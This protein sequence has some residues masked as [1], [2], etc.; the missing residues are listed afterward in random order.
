MSIRSDAGAE[1]LAPPHRESLLMVMA[2]AM[3]LAF[4]VWMAMLNNFTENVIGF[5][6][7]DIGAIQAIREIPGFLAFLVVYLILVIREQRLALVS[8]F[9][10]GLGVAMT[11]YLPFF[12][13]VA[14]TT[15]ISSIG[16]HYFETT[17][18]S[19][20]LQWLP[21]DRAPIVMG[22]LAGIG[23]STAFLAFGAIFLVS[24]PWT[25]NALGL[26]AP[27]YETLYLAGGLATMALAVYA[28]TAFPQFESE[29]EQKKSIVLKR[30]YWLYYAFVFLGGARRQIFVVFAAFM[31]VEA[32]DYSLSDFALLLIVNHAV[33]TVFAPFMGRMTARFGERAIL[34]I[35]Y[36]GLIGVFAA[37]M[38]VTDPLA[39]AALYIINHL[40]FGLYF[41][42]RTYF[43]KIADPEDMAPT[44]SVAFTIN[45]IAAVALPLPL[46]LLYLVAPSAVFGLG[47]GLAFLSLIC[48][49]LVPRWPE[50]GRE[51]LWPGAP[52]GAAL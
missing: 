43:Q 52:R 12:W 45:H 23:S 36:V 38:V 2:L 13:G 4:S 33:N 41:A 3:P 10:L 28:W 16:F 20:Q 15:I 6:G 35:E 48:A 34:T 46:G 49:R 50:K 5:D 40:F 51:T 22:R 19:L 39:A 42:Q 8:L 17:N 27:P 11:G 29:A 9:L 30:R 21:K 25:Q 31:M 44:A 26:T 32:F 18:Q 47:V 14:L 7:A 37:Y 1:A 24:N